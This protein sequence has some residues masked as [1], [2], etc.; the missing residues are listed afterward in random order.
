MAKERHRE[1]ERQKGRNTQPPFNPSVGSLCHF[2]VTPTH[3]SYRFSIFETSATA[4]C[5]T[6][7]T[8]TKRSVNNKKRD[9]AGPH[10]N[11]FGP[12][13]AKTRRQLLTL[14]AVCIARILVEL[15]RRRWPIYWVK[16]SVHRATNARFRSNPHDVRM[17]NKSMCQCH[18]VS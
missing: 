6:T 7:G 9:E 11:G 2:C 16:S 10:Q 12:F 5:G 1:K 13:R 18:D 8:C 3:L 14:A 15:L 4:L 17:D